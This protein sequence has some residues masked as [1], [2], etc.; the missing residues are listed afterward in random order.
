[1]TLADEGSILFPSITI[2]KDEMY[3][4][5]GGIFSRNKSQELSLEE[6]KLLFKKRTLSQRQVVKFLSIRTLEGSNNYPCTAVS[7]P[8]AGE[9]CA[10]PFVFPDC[11]QTDKSVVCLEEL[12]PRSYNS[13]VLLDT[14]PEPWCYT[15]VYKNRSQPCLENLKQSS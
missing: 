14:D 9:G 2:C 6:T 3:N 11:S 5:Y 7:G 10:F 13:C 8:R 4:V 15:R 1:M 12:E